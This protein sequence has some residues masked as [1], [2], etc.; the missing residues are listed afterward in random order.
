M[1][2][3][4]QRK[5]VVS[6]K[7][8]APNPNYGSDGDIQVRQTN[9]GAKLFGKLG[10]RWLS[11][12]LFSDNIFSMSDNTGRETIKLDPGV[13]LSVD[14]IKLTGKIEITS[15]G[16]D[17]VVIGTGNI[18]LGTKNVVV[19]VDAG[20]AMTSSATDNVFIGY[21][22]GEALTG[23]TKNVCIGSG[24]GAAMTGTF[25]NIMIGLSAGEVIATGY[26]STYIGFRATASATYVINEVVICGGKVG[27]AQTVGKGSN[28]IVLGADTVT[29]IY[30]SQDSGATVHC[31]FL[32][33]K[34]TSTPTALA[35]HGK[36]YT[37]NT[38]KLFF[39]DGAGTEHEISFE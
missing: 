39:Q 7:L 9:L 24:A 30:M 26:F 35:D 31:Q 1:G 22:A 19:G 14:Q 33:L 18:D 37:K 10:G 6:N 17:N 3:G 12:N 34:E 32:A 29:D 38:N 16:S 36:I 13:G 21:E 20:K 23:G 28:T 4:Q 27:A 8:G 11:T 25:G 15:V 2:W 5:T